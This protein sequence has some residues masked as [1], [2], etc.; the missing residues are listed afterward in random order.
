MADSGRKESTMKYTVIKGTSI[1]RAYIEQSDGKRKVVALF[2][3]VSDLAAK[4]I[5]SLEDKPATQKWIVLFSNQKH[6]TPEFE[7]KEQCKQIIESKF[8]EQ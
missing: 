4:N 3:M 5:I 7:S 1:H 2:G 6:S 8:P